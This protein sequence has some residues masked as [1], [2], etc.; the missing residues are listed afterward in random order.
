MQQCDQTSFC[1]FPYRRVFW[2]PGVGEGSNQMIFFSSDLYFLEDPIKYLPRRTV[3][4]LF[5]F[6]HVKKP[7]SFIRLCSRAG[8]YNHFSC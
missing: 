2:S 6:L 7:D 1:L 8:P 5:I 4:L 3:M